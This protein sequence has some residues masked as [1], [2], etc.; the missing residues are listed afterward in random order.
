MI[1]FRPA[2]RPSPSAFSDGHFCIQRRFHDGNSVTIFPPEGTC[3]QEDHVA[4]NVVSEPEAAH[5][6][7]VLAVTRPDAL[8]F[9]DGKT[10]GLVV[11]IGTEHG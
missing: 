6:D 5:P 4:L 8:Q 7:A 3:F 9:L 10:P 2:Y 11:G 1:A